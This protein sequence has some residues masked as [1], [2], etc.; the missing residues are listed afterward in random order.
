MSRSCEI[1]AEVVTH[2][3]SSLEAEG[4]PGYPR[5]L[6]CSN[7]RHHA[8]T[9]LIITLLH[10]LLGKTQGLKLYTKCLHYQSKSSMFVQVEGWKA[11]P[12]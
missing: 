3:A 11:S 9:K 6:P 12:S 7:K 10:K 2:V 4:L 5:I 1:Y 8:L